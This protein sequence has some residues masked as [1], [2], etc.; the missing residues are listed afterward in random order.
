MMQID[1][2]ASLTR[3]SLARRYARIL[4]P[5]LTGNWKVPLTRR[6][7]SLR[8]VAQT[9]LSAGSGDFPVARSIVVALQFKNSVKMRTRRHATRNKVLAFS[10]SSYTVSPLVRDVA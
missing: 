1:P 3:V 2:S 4:T 9:F 6:L 8:H 7:E 10:H 5:F